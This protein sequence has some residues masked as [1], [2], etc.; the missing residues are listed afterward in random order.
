[1]FTSSVAGTLNFS[2]TLSGGCG[3]FG[4]DDF[5]ITRNG[6]SVWNPSHDTLDGIV[7]RSTT[8]AVSPG[9]IIRVVITNEYNANFRSFSA[10]V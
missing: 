5:T 7:S 2:V 10:Y 8:F 6:I 1:M 4:C 3:D 9:N